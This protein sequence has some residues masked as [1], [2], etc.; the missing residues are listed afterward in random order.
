M[1]LSGWNP[2]MELGKE[3]FE[4]VAARERS[5]TPQPG[6]AQEIDARCPRYDF[7]RIEFASLISSFSNNDLPKCDEQWKRKPFKRSELEELA[8]I[9]LKMNKHEIE[10]RIRATYYSG[11]P[12][13]Y[14]EIHG[15]KFEYNPDR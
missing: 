10:E 5:C 3:P 14:I 1:A 4:D 2:L 12:A 9:N 6:D 8:T 11:K 7:S 15:Y 13:P